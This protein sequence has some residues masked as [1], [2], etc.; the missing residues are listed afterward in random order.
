[1]RERYEEL[2]QFGYKLIVIAP[3]KGSF[4]QEF[5]NQFGDY[6]FPFY[7]DPDKQAYDEV[8][9]K[10]MPKGKLLMKSLKGMLKGTVSNVIP[11]DNGQKDV[12]MKSMKSEDVSIQG[13]TLILDEKGKMTFSHLDESPEDRVNVDQLF[14]VLKQQS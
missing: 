1:M 12:V 5:L 13:A 8:G 2:E 4:V 11:K 6:P 9:T 14:D 7:G 3:H 10:T